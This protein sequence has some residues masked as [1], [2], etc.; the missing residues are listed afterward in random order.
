MKIKFN[1]IN[2]FFKYS[3][4]LKLVLAKKFPEGE[5]KTWYKRCLLEEYA[6]YVLP[7]GLVA[8]ICRFHDMECTPGN[9]YKVEEIYENRHD[10]LVR[11]IYDIDS[12]LV[13]EYFTEGR[14]DSAHGIYA[15]YIQNVKIKIYFINP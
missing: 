4:K 14:D 9:L 7:D 2:S 1:Y 5:R 11:L 10:H 15:F 13:I 3:H 12:G 8:R 6:P